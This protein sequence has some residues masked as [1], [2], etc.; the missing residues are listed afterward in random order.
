[1]SLRPSPAGRR[2]HFEGG[3]A[4]PTFKPAA[5][6]RPGVGQAKAAD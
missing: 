4:M 5:I 3:L 6:V 2:H 1:M